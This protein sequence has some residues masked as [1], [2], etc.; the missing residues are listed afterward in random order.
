[1]RNVDCQTL[2]RTRNPRRSADDVEDG[3][4]LNENGGLFFFF[5]L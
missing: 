1:M 5:F 3:N 4:S 2:L